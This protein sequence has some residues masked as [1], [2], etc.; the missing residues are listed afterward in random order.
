MRPIYTAIDLTEHELP[1][2]VNPEWRISAYGIALQDESILLMKSDR[3]PGWELPG[4]GIEP[5]E[6]YIDGLKRE[7]LEETG[8]QVLSVDDSK[9]HVLQNR[10]YH[11][12]KEKYFD[13]IKLTCLIEVEQH[14]SQDIQE[15][16]EGEVAELA[17]VPLNEITI[18]DIHPGHRE[19][20]KYFLDL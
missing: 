1:E 16:V 6:H 7:V 17:W 5:S 8:R 14:A 2:G 11:L 9:V 12:W 20:I 10:Y 18:D 19:S 13:G 4:G 3:S 15:S